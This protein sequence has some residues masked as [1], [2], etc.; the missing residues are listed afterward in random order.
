[1]SVHHLNPTRER[2]DSNA[3]DGRRRVA[4]FVSLF[5]L[6]LVLLLRHSLRRA[7]YRMSTATDASGRSLELSMS[8]AVAALLV[9]LCLYQTLG[10]WGP[11]PLFAYP[12]TQLHALIEGT[13]WTWQIYF[14][15]S[16]YRWVELSTA[17]FIALIGPWQARSAF[18]RRL[19]AADPAKIH[20]AFEV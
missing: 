6:G 19:M 2:D 10:S 14:E 5:A 3:I 13:P 20:S 8:L 11:L 1:M 12:P 4:A 16:E 7:A 18:T 15:R 17:L 9:L